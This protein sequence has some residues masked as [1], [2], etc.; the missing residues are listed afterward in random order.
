MKRSSYEKLE[1]RYMFESHT[2]IHEQHN[3]IISEVDEVQDEVIAI[4][5]QDRLYF[6]T[7]LTNYVHELMDL[8]MA[9]NNQLLRMEREYGKGFLER[10]MNDF[11]VKMEDYKER[12]YAEKD[13]ATFELVK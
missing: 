3:K 11:D 10:T 4:P 1:R 8:Q 13:K 7:T 6:K 12:K 9:I 2:S 5:E